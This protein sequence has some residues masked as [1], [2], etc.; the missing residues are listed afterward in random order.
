M[1]GLKKVIGFSIV[2]I[3]IVSLL[4]WGIITAG[5]FIDVICGLGI[6]I[7]VTGLMLFGLWLLEE[8]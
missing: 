4:L 7:F 5:E 2:T 1:T 6:A 3:P 8:K